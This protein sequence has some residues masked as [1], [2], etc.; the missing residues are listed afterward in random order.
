MIG[1]CRMTQTGDSFADFLGQGRSDYG[2][3]G[4]IYEMLRLIGRHFSHP[5]TGGGSDA[6]VCIPVGSGF[7][8]NAAGGLRSSASLGLFA[9]TPIGLMALVSFAESPCRIVSGLR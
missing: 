7:E 4:P 9:L 2:Y 5:R 8:G 6:Y 1:L 3:G